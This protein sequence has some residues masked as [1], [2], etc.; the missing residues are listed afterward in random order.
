MSRGCRD[1]AEQAPVPVGEGR[2]LGLAAQNGELV[3]QHDHLEILRSSRAHRQPSQRHKEP[4]QDANHDPQAWTITPGQ[5]PR[6]PISGTHRCDRV[7]PVAVEV[8][9][10]DGRGGELFVGDLDAG[11]VVTL[12]EAGVDS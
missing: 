2:P 7:V 8:V 3:A 10:G 12:I 1:R 11:R 9:F 6:A 4:V 5:R